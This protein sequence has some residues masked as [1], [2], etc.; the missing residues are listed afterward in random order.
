VA[1]PA[2]TVPSC[3]AGIFEASEE[4]PNF[5]DFILDEPRRIILPDTSVNR[6]Q[7]KSKSRQILPL[8][9]REVCLFRIYAKDGRERTSEN[10]VNA[11]IAEFYF[12]ALGE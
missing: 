7:R 10:S 6:G 11:K 8:C 3:H 4:A 5:R 1:D 2:W 12:C 9:L